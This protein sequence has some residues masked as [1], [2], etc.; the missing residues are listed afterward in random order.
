MHTHVSFHIPGGS[1]KI[2]NKLKNHIK[3][4]RMPVHLYRQT[5]SKKLSLFSLEL[6]V[7][8]KEEFCSFYR[9]TFN[10]IFRSEL[11]RE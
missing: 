8:E 4:F 2:I 1:L 7:C 11:I 6:T 5:I 9:N 10:M 3:S